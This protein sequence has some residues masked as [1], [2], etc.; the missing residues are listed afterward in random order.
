MHA[1]IHTRTNARI[2]TQ[3]R[4]Y[5]CLCSRLDHWCRALSVFISLFL[6][7][8]AWA[9]CSAARWSAW[10]CDCCAVM[11]YTLTLTYVY[12]CMY[13]IHICM[14][15]CDVMYRS[16]YI[17]AHDHTCKHAYM[18]SPNGRAQTYAHLSRAHSH[19]GRHAEQTHTHTSRTSYIECTRTV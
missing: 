7:V 16:M 11:L 15:V 17:P 19:T 9:Y 4:L 2:Q 1:C 14:Y 12:I 6:S 10:F 5:L 8:D 13:V 18:C 3:T